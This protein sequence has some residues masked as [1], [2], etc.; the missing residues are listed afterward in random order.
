[1]ALY[2]LTENARTIPVRAKLGSLYL[3]GRWSVG[4]LCVV[5]AL[6]HSHFDFDQ[7]AARIWPQLL[8]HRLRA[9]RSDSFHLRRSAFGLVLPSTIYSGIVWLLFVYDMRLIRARLN[10][11]H[12]PAEHTPFIFTPDPISC[13][14]FGARAAPLLF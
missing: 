8:L 7:M 3:R 1:V 2:F 5:V 13:S 6:G 4:D 9:G 11:P 10:E 12:S 14:T